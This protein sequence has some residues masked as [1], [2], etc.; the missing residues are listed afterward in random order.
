[1]ADRTTG[2]ARPANPARRDGS[3]AFVAVTGMAMSPC[4]NT[5]I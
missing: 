5:S 2:S 1:M 4:G 3:H